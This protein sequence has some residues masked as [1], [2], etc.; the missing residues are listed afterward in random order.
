MAGATGATSADLV[1]EAAGNVP[2]DTDPGRNDRD[3]GRAV[4]G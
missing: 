3:T 1:K 2:D 4:D